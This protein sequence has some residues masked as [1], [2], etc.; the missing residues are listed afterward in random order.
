ME[1]I[2][3][4]L[5]IAVLNVIREPAGERHAGSPAVASCIGGE[6]GLQPGIVTQLAHAPANAD[7]PNVAAVLLG[8]IPVRSAAV[9]LRAHAVELDPPDRQCV[10]LRVRWWFAERRPSA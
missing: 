3:I 6:D 5:L 7:Q 8:L 1:T 10:S 2:S 9:F 4:L